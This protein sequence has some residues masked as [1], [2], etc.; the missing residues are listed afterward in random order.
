M[1]VY[2]K[3]NFKIRSDLLDEKTI[4]AEEQRDSGDWPYIQF[5]SS[6]NKKTYEKNG[7]AYSIFLYDSNPNGQQIDDSSPNTTMYAT[8]AHADYQNVIDYV[9]KAKPKYVIVDNYRTKQAI[10]LTK[11]LK[12][13]GFTVEC[14]PKN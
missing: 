1:N 7:K 12:S 3:Y 5:L 14:Q 8:T 13:M 6:F 10:S 2:K 11:N 9:V 4:E